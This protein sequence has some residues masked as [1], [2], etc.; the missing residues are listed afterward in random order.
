MEREKLLANLRTARGLTRH[1]LSKLCGVSARSLARFEGGE[2]PK[3]NSAVSILLALE[4]AGSLDADETIATLTAWGLSGG[5]LERI[6]HDIGRERTAKMGPIKATT[7]GHVSALRNFEKLMT[8]VGADRTADMLNG[9][10]L[11]EQSRHSTVPVIKYSGDPFEG[12]DGKMYKVTRY[13]STEPKKPSR[14]AQRKS[15]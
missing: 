15:S 5:V 6:R 9:L 11:A 2:T 1:A 4:K 14:S 7:Q 8:L 13:E 3:G 10:V 12:P